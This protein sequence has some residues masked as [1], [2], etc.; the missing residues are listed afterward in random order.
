MLALEKKNELPR[1]RVMWLAVGLALFTALAYFLMAAN[2]LGVGD[3][4]PEEGPPVIIYVAAGCYLLGG[5]LILLRRRWLWIF[6]AVMN[7]L[8]IVFFVNLYASRPAVLFSP[9]GLAS[10]SA[11]LLLELCLVY[12]IFTGRAGSRRTAVR[13]KAQ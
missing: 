1:V 6:G 10:K 4:Q 11:Q 8:V 12:L 13:G 9:G 2:V 7:G 5:L 3:L